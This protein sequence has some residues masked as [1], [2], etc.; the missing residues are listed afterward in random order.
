MGGQDACDN[1]ASFFGHEVTIGM[2][3][4]DDKTVSAKDAEAVGDSG[5]G[6]LSLL[7]GS[8]GSRKEPFDDIA[9]TKAG[10][11]KLAPRDG[12]KQVQL[13]LVP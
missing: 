12:P 11:K 10:A 8:G 2:L 6:T 3:N 4:F 5:S 13:V 7:R 9:I 1:A